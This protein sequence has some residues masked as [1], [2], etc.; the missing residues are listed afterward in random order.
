MNELSNIIQTFDKIDFKVHKAALATVV[1]I[2]GSSYR[3]PGARMLI[4]DDGHWEGA[5]SGGCLEGDALRKAREIMRSGQSRHI[6]YDTRKDK[7]SDHIPFSMGCEGIIDVLLEPLDKESA[8]L[9]PIKIFREFASTHQKQLMV[10]LY[11]V[12]HE[13]MGK[14]GERLHIDHK[15][16]IIDNFSNPEVRKAVRNDAVNLTQWDQ[17][18]QKEMRIKSHQIYLFYEILTPPIHLVIFGGGFDVVP[19]VKLAKNL[20]WLVT[21][22]DEC[23]AKTF[24]QKF[25]DADQVLNIPGVE[26]YKEVREMTNIYSVIMSH[27]FK[28]DLEV[29]KGLLKTQVKYIGVLG[30]KK[31]IKTM[32]DQLKSEV[33]SSW[34]DIEKRIYSPVGLNI[35]AET[36][37]E[38]ALSIITEILAVHNKKP[39]GF[40][41]D[42]KGHIHDRETALQ[43]I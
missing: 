42:K 35:G 4:L 33:K 28:Y 6:T 15:G 7:P 9:H 3:Q 31:R 2:E 27:N 16:Q 32:M 1:K 36:P 38:I 21:V 41:K 24:P 22:A 8:G 37:E 12:T 40:L 20:G 43:M 17:S 10:T 13:S 18:F 5:I 39:G 11:D 34:K 26:V 14:P 29:L 25:P 23:I 19:V 30:P